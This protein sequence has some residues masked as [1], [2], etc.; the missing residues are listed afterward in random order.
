MGAWW[1]RPRV[2]GVVDILTG[3][4]LRS[5]EPSGSGVRLKLDGPRQ[6]DTEVDHVIAG[7]GFRIDMARLSFLSEEIRAGIVTRADCPMVNR[8]GESTVPRPV[9]RRA[10]TP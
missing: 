5:A 9:L 8:A 10:P 7:T 4:A 6:T 1:L 2:E 3:H